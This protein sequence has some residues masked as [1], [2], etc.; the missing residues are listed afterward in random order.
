MGNNLCR[1][2]IP[3]ALGPLAACEKKSETGSL[4]VVAASDGSYEIYRIA[5][6]SPLQ[7]V[8]EQAGRFNRDTPLV[9]GSYLVLADCSSETV[10]IYPGRRET[11]VAHRLEFVPPHTPSRQDG[12]SVQCS[13]SDKTRSRQHIS[14]RFELNVLHGKRD[15]LV[16]M[17]PLRIDFDAAADRSK[18]ASLSYKLSSLQ[19]EGFS[20]KDE[21]MSYFVSPVDELTSVTKSQTFGHWEF[22]L[23]GRYV[24]EVNGTTMQ[25]ALTEG[26]ERVVK[27]ARLSVTTSPEVDLAEAVKIK[28]SPWLVEINGGHWLNFNESYPVLPGK[29]VVGISGST[30]SIEIELAEGAELELMARS[31]RVDLGCPPTEPVCLGDKAVSL[32]RAEEPYPFVES[33]SDIP[34]IYIEE[35]VPILVGVEGSRDITYELATKERDKRLAVGFVKL[36]PQPMH[37]SSQ[38][39]DLVRVE[40]NGAP[41]AGHTLDINLEKPTLMPLVAG[42]YTLAHHFS[43]ASAESERRHV[44]Q[45]FSIEPGKTI[46]I[47]IPVFFNEKRFAAWKKKNDDK[48]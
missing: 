6:E 40:A 4:Q 48:G 11:L 3:V 1:I 7:F 10:I 16:G 35:Q 18:P 31:V 41:L 24:L 42:H 15:L 13:R 37:R 20:G 8:S 27:P 19:I 25:V 30:Q 34:I 5:N 21:E 17:V 43:M 29:A 47:E 9:P 33:V 39:T 14:N 26:E 12:F 45:S 38:V 44:S 32:Y 36:L 22:L 23:P 2:L 46:E 28:G